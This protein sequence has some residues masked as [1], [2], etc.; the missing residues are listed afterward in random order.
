[1]LA[2]D[3]VRQARQLLVQQLGQLDVG[4]PVTGGAAP[5]QLGEAGVARGQERPQRVHLG[6]QP[7]GRPPERRRE[8]GGRLRVAAD[9]VDE[10]AGDDTELGVDVVEASVDRRLEVVTDRDV[11]VLVEAAE[12]AVEPAQ[13]EQEPAEQA[14]HRNE[15]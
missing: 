9:P 13:R 3:A 14:F 7:V 11:D 10:V 4:L 6:V 15:R 2:H 5:K 12:P 8:L 1:V